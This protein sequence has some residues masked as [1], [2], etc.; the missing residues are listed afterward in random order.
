MTGSFA[1][2]RAWPARRWAAALAA[3][4]ATVLVVGVPTVLVPN[5][6]FGREVPV[7]WWA[8]PVLLLTATLS[9]LLLATYVRTSP[10]LPADPDRDRPSRLGAAGGFLG[11]LAVGCPVCN[12]VALL[13]L[14]YTG[15]LRWFAPVQPLLAAAGLALLGYALHRRL[16]GE[17]ACPLPAPTDVSSRV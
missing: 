10:A 8:W 17:V 15:A 16:R 2:L 6:V 12:K 3:A 13:A 7:T 9:G 14:G 1:V 4:G 5:P 11:Y